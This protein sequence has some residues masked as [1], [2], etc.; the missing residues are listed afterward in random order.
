MFCTNCGAKNSEKAKF[1]KVCGSELTVKYEKTDAVADSGKKIIL[2]V[3]IVGVILFVAIMLAIF[4]FGGR[5]REDFRN[6]TVE[7]DIASQSKS[8]PNTTG[9]TS[10]TVENL[11]RDETK[12]EEG[13]ADAQEVQSA[14]V[15]RIEKTVHI[16]TGLEW[17]YSEITEYDRDGNE[18]YISSDYGSW[19]IIYDYYENGEPSIQYW[20]NLDGILTTE[21]HFDERGNVTR[22]GTIEYET[23]YAYTYEYDEQGRILKKFSY[24]LDANANPE[25]ERCDIYEY[26]DAGEPVQLIL[27]YDEALQTPVYTYYWEYDED[28]QLVVYYSCNPDGRVGFKTEYNPDL[29][30]EDTYKDNGYGI[31]YLAEHKEYNANGDLLAEKYYNE[32]GETTKVN[33]YVY[34]YKYDT[35]GNL[36]EKLVYLNNELFITVKWEYY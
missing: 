35:L 29:N 17:L 33:Q 8:N 21:T 11:E 4:G 23:A 13:E 27:Y 5:P 26:N 10:E 22:E 18:V 2:L 16:E 3:A 25:F 15:R 12:K 32:A 6:N 24:W 14:Q 1:C 31:L 7:Q 19:N 36:I 28:N 9:Q 34:D 30:T 20:Y